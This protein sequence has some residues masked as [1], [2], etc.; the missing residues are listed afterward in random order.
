MSFFLLDS[1]F[2]DRR[3]FASAFSYRYFNSTW[4]TRREYHCT[5]PQYRGSCT[6]YHR[7]KLLHVSLPAIY[8]DAN[9]NPFETRD[10][11]YWLIRIR[12]ESSGIQSVRDVNS[13]NERLGDSV[14]NSVTLP[15]FFDRVQTDAAGNAQ[16]VIF[17][18]NLEQT[19]I[20]DSS[21]SISIDIV[22]SVNTTGL[23]TGD[24]APPQQPIRSRQSVIFFSLSPY[25][26]PNQYSNEYTMLG[27]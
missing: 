2:R 18:P 27:N 8:F 7:L 5:K 23:N 10:Q 20:I 22:D 26:A 16:Y 19:Y 12:N 4:K 9:G 6:V 17:R 21:K 3:Q 13:N 14:I 11:P 15:I 1:Y 25:D 24:T